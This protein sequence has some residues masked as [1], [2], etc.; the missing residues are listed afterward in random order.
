MD[1]ITIT[2]ELYNL[3]NQTLVS[4]IPALFAQA[5]TI[6]ETLL[7]QI[8][9]NNVSCEWGKKYHFDQI[10]ACAEQKGNLPPEHCLSVGRRVIIAKTTLQCKEDVSCSISKKLRK[11]KYS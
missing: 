8:I 4:K 6:Q 7:K 2:E 9:A 10:I 5:A 11:I 1:A 3:D